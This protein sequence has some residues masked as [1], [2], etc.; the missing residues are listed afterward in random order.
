[1]KHLKVTTIAVA[2]T[3][4]LTGIFQ[5]PTVNAADKFSTRA[6]EIVRKNEAKLA[7]RST[8]IKE[9]F[10]TRASDLKEKIAS[11]GAQNKENRTQRLAK[12]SEN[13][14]LRFNRV[15]ERQENILKRANTRIASMSAEGTNVTEL[16]TKSAS[17]SALIAK[18][19]TSIA[20]LKTTLSA[21]VKTQGTGGTTIGKAISDV[22]KQVTAT[23]KALRDLVHSIAKSLPEKE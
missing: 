21:L 1:M 15:T 11:R 12:L 23:H 5:V 19:K 22:T 3:L 4:A 16:N 6:A 8:N 9:R 20:A 7:T 17:V 14:T 18:Q 10:A 13:L 2:T